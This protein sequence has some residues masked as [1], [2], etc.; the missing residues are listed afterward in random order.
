[1]TD[2]AVQSKIADIFFRL[3]IFSSDCDL[4]MYS[5]RGDIETVDSHNNRD[6]FLVLLKV[7]AENDSV[8]HAHLHQPRARNVTYLS[9]KKLLALM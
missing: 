8:L 7:F 9:P 4:F 1:M 5:L 2:Q 6:N 3:L